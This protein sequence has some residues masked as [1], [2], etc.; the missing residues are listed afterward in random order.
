MYTIDKI[1]FSLAFVGKGLDPDE[2]TPILNI[3]PTTSYREGDVYYASSGEKRGVRRKGAWIYHD[4]VYDVSV[5]ED[6]FDSFVEK[7]LKMKNKIKSISRNPEVEAQIFVG[8]FG[9]R[10]P[11]Y[12]T[13]SPS[14]LKKLSNLGLTF[15]SSFYTY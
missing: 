4:V 9:G 7:L 10:D 13:L 12:I 5:Q 15:H 6:A 11:P 3:E 14:T 1:D 8:V 2:I